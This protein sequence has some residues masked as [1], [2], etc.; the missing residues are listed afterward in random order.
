MDIHLNFCYVGCC[1]YVLA[2][3]AMH[4]AHGQGLAGVTVALL[5]ILTLLA[6]SNVNAAA[7]LFFCLSLGVLF[8]CVGECLM[9]ANTRHT[10]LLV[11][12]S[13]WSAVFLRPLHP[14]VIVSVGYVVLL[15]QPVVQYYIKKSAPVS[16]VVEKVTSRCNRP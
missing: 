1:A 11:H 9:S 3:D 12:S 2:Y 6:G 14:S 10:R 4:T 13:S 5:N 16:S 8:V 7:F 15:R